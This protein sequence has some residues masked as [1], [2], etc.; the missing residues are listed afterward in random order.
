MDKDEVVARL[1]I[2]EGKLQSQREQLQ[3]LKDE[4]AEKDKQQKQLKQAL[5]QIRK[6]Y[7]DAQNEFI[8]S[9][10]RLRAKEY[11]SKELKSEAE[12][13]Q[14]ELARI[15]D[16]E[17]LN[18]D[19]LAM[20][21]SLR[22]SS[23]QATWRG[24]NRDD[25]F[26]AYPHQIDGAIHLAVAG[27]ALLGDKRGLGKS[28]TSLIFADLKDSMKTIIIS[29]RDTQDNY[30]REVMRWTPHR[31]PIKIGQMPKGQREFILQSLAF[32]PTFTIILNYEAWRKDPDL[33]KQ[34]IKLEADTVIV[35]EAHNAKDTRSLA[36]KGIQ[37]IVF[38]LNQCP[39]GKG[40]CG[41]PRVTQDKDDPW[42]AECACGY[43]AEITNFTSVKNY[44]PMTGTPILN[45]P[46]EL[47]P[48]LH[49]I[50]PKTWPDEHSF[51][52]DFTIKIGQRS[53]WKYGAEETLM[54][55]IGPRYLART[56]EDAGIIIPP[57]EEIE[58]IL[59][60]AEM[61]E[62]YP[63]QF[64]AYQQARDA[65]MIALDPGNSEL[66]MSFPYL[67]TQ[68]MR[69]RQ[70]LVWPNA[71]QLKVLDPETYEP[72]GEVVPL[73]VKESIKLDTAE[74]L[75]REFIEEGER[76]VLFSQFRP[77]L[78]ILQERIGGRSVIYSGSTSER[79]RNEIQL[80]FD[81]TIK[82]P[83]PRWDV[84]LGIYKSGG[85][86]LNFTGASQE[87]LLDREWNPGKQDQAVGRIDRI[88]QTRDTQTHQIIVENSVDIWMKELNQEKADM[89]ENFEGIASLYQR[90]YDKLRNGEI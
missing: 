40:G 75:I 83:N 79:L 31:M 20:V 4:T 62:L 77:G 14:R 27:R 51:K 9:R 48:H 86:G 32:A 10:Q 57:N 33:I 87:I 85:T 76:V 3:E 25:G 89:T 61:E 55:K 73:N 6:L 66:V 29:P 35:D 74:R 39:V 38:G 71:I 56:K 54:K 64:K 34:L 26:G 67:I 19:Y 81:A 70:V 1:N 58:H 2:L 90:T 7:D 46:E 72:T 23:L 13:L 30:I 12:S 37:D 41:L 22:E 42:M 53:V 49:L 88:G 16:A 21:N 52:D 45:K 69:L 60:M 15:L 82:N 36:F 28:L 5:E 78:S 84:L 18:A 80:D 47:Y 24:E 17:K 43:R 11:E 65:A 63:A 50:D 68:L 59:T 44:L 8:Q